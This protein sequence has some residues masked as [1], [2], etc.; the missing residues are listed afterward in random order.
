MGHV[1]RV[2][3]D[4]AKGDEE[5]EVE[6]GKGNE[7]EHDLDVAG[8][9]AL[10]MRCG[11]DDKPAEVLTAPHFS[12]PAAPNR[13]DR[14]CVCVYATF[15]ARSS[16]WTCVVSQ[17]TPRL[18]KDEH[19]KECISEPKSFSCCCSFCFWKHTYK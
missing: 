2:A 16:P 11:V 5:E 13:C 6:W 14:V 10:Q 3:G 8:I 9:E 18:N 4:H 15:Q 12:H 17:H 7:E 19:N 1:V